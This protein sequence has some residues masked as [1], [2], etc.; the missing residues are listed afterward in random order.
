MVDD[1]IL[2]AKTFND[3]VAIR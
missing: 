2:N 3:Q 1:Y